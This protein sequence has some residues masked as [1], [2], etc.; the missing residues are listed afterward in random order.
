MLQ[1][2]M[3]VEQIGSSFHLGLG[4]LEVVACEGH[5]VT[6]QSIIWLCYTIS[7]ISSVRIAKQS[8]WV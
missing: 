6:I 1:I 5:E 8:H 4:W 7:H 3:Q 2:R